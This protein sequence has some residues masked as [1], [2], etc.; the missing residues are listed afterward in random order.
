MQQKR[1]NFTLIL[2]NLGNTMRFNNK[3]SLALV[4][5]ILFAPLSFAQD[6]SDLD[7]EEIEEVVVTGSKLG[8]SNFEADVPI[9]TITSEEITNRLTNTAG[10]AVAR[11]PN[12]ALTNSIQGDAYQAASGVGQNI[13][14]LFGLGSQ[15][16]LT[17]VNGRR[18]VSS[19]SPQ[20]G[21]AA[22]GLQVDTNNIPIL[23]IDRIEV[24]NV[25]GASVYGA[26]AVAGVINYVLKEDFEGF[27]LQYDY[28]NIADLSEDKGVKMLFGAN[29]DDGRGNFALSV[30]YN[31]TGHIT[32]EELDQEGQ[33]YRGGFY[34]VR[35]SPIPGQVK[36]IQ[37]YAVNGLD[38]P[39]IITRGAL[40]L[41][42]GCSFQ[43][44][45]GTSR[46]TGWTGGKNYGF[47]NA[48]N[49]VEKA[50]GTATGNTVWADGG[51]GVRLLST[52]PY[53]NPSERTNINLFINYE[54]TDDLKARVEMYSSEFSA[55]EGATQPYISN[56]LFPPPYSALRMSSSNPFL[57]QDA[58][59][60]LAAEGADNFFLGK[61]WLDLYDPNSNDV[62]TDMF[63]FSLEGEVGG[64]NWEAGLSTGSSSI[65][66][67][68]RNLNYLRLF[69][70]LDAGVNPDTN[71]IDCKWNYDSDYENGNISDLGLPAF[72]GA[73]FGK[74]GDCKP[75]DPFGLAQNSQESL[76]YVTANYYD[77]A[78]I[79]QDIAYFEIDGVIAELP[80]G[81]VQALF[82][83]ETR[84]EKAN[85]MSGFGASTRLAYEAG[86]GGDGSQGGQ[87]DSDDFY[88]EARVPLVSSDM[89]VPGVQNLELSL[90]FRE[91]DHSYAG[92]DSTEGFGITWDIIDDLTF[93][94][95]SQATVRAPNVGELFKPVLEGSS[96]TRD[97]CDENYL[98]EGPAPDVRAA[99]CAADGLVNFTS[100]AKNASVR[101]T[102]GGNLN[103]MNEEADTTSYGFVY[104]PSFH[105]IVEGLQIAV[106]FIEFD[107]QNAITTFTLTQVMEACYDSTSFPNNQFCDAFNRGPDG[108][109]PKE[110][111]YNVGVVNAAYYLF[112]TY[113]YEIA[114]N[115]N[116]NEFLGLLG[117]DVAYDLGDFGIKTIWYKKDKDIFS[118]TGF[119]EDDELGAFS[120]PDNR[121]T[122]Q[123][124]WE[125]GKYFS[126]LDLFYRGGGK[127]NDDWDDKASP[128]RYLDTQ[129]NP[130]SNDVDGYY[131]GS[132]GLIYS[133]NDNFKLNL[134]V[135]NV[136]DRGP[137]NDQELAM[138]PSAW[139]GR[140]ISGGFQINF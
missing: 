54:I 7:D 106:D 78:K 120:N 124:S 95:K 27:K 136:F 43:G 119:D 70:A 18:F 100:Q 50:A 67:H 10:N 56:G 6:N 1:D 125:K 79:R 29:F 134:R 5:T 25:G 55:Q 81:E 87:F 33:Y 46:C 28:N 45:T 86:G 15:R 127:L 99:N 77:L 107:I 85:F 122:T 133:L 57:P 89:N 32:L 19:N 4:A 103:L 102:S 20:G 22:D 63:R 17:L 16:T 40:F 64:F 108:Q 135:T 130:L 118:A 137:E 71:R 36:L 59:D 49:F 34:G 62:D 138:Y 9:L 30:D 105:P 26:D 35:G 131:N 123:F 11:L 66:A 114:Y 47:D 21:A 116:V 51:A 94:A 2:K 96:F 72:S 42:S 88:M 126:Y 74:K 140:S 113:I 97:P 14:S 112:D 23:L 73:I 104:S 117:A 31:E 65:Y 76:D 93:R 84:T 129:G 83:F 68:Q 41:P 82:G 75:Y 39:G 58:R 121:V 53:L 111:A 61:W 52:D 139:P 115:K 12:A 91:I 69:L 38:K 132:F 90:S 109:L 92:S 8:R 60:F 101:G 24:N 44:G 128:E 48:G 3:F 13:V 37:D 110:G 80:A 98:I